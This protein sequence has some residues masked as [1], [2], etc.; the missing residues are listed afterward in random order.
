MY[1]KP[2]AQ[3]MQ[4]TDTPSD[5]E[6]NEK[7]LFNSEKTYRAT[8]NGF[9]LSP[10][11]EKRFKKQV[12]TALWHNKRSGSKHIIQTFQETYNSGRFEH[13]LLAWEAAERPQGCQVPFH[14]TY[15]TAKAEN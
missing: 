8:V 10:P 13:G 4:L 14:C 9:V 7:K 5:S 6:H 12:K 15:G 3:C 11:D 2:D 1:G